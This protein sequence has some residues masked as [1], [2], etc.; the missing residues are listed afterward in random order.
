MELQCADYHNR[1]L[2][3]SYSFSYH[4][5]VHNRFF[6]R[7]QWLEVKADILKKELKGLDN[8]H[9]VLTMEKSFP[10]QNIYI[11]STSTYLVENR[12]FKP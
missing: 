2:L 5:K 11:H 8:D 9:S 7:K 6:M 12:Y 10:I 3:D 1:S 4:D